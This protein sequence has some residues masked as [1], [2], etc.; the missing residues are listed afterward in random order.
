MAGFSKVA[1]MAARILILP[2]PACL[3]D[4]PVQVKIEGLSPLQ[5]VTVSASLVDESGNLFQSRA[6]YRA[7]GNGAL[8][9]SCSPSLGGSYCGVEPMG[10]LWALESPTP[11]KRL[12][13]R[14]VL[15]PFCVTY[16]VYDGRGVSGSLL[17]RCLSER[18]FMAEGVKRVPVREGRLRATLFCPP[19]ELQLARVDGLKGRGSRG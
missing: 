17:C 7:E 2:S 1:Q 11:H 5:E 13:K 9:L 12:R 14:N 8:D 19:G 4:E 18:R 15:T 16:E 10:L 3:Y 6:Y